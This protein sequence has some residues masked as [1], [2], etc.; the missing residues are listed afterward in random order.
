MEV[1]WNPVRADEI[2]GKIGRLKK[3]EKSLSWIFIIIISEAKLLWCINNAHCEIV[4]GVLALE[5]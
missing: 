4:V 5:G 3:M 2:C 1:F